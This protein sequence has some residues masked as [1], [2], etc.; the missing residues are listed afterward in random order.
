MTEHQVKIRY[1]IK[2]LRYRYA[3]PPLGE[4]AHYKALNDI[5]TNVIWHS[6]PVTYLDH[7][8][9]DK[10]ISAAMKRR[11]QA[12]WRLN[13]RIRDMFECYDELWFATFTFTDEAL[14][15][16]N[17]RTQHR[18]MQAWLLEN[19][20]DYV[21]NEDFGKKNGRRHYHAVIAKNTAIEPWKYGFY[22]LK[23][24]K[25]SDESS[26]HKL[27]SYLLKLVNHANKL[28]TGK[29]FSKRGLK[30]VDNLPF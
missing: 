6:Y 16:L 30:E 14:E 27:S 23:K 9:S 4:E 25:M 17:E 28:T 29:H 5:L 24:V 19:C 22:K 1:L 3:H 7:E 8:S 12:K 13:R 11:R 26:V 2:K 10:L 20:R 15:Q 18:Y 21:A